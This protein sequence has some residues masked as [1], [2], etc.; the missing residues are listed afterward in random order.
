MHELSVCQGLIRQ[1]GR[2][3]AEHH[4]TRVDKIFLQI[5]PLSGVE[6]A[7]LQAAFPI[8]RHNTLV[9]QAEMVIQSMPVRI[10]CK[11]CGEESEATL[12]NLT[13]PACGD[14]NTDLLSGDE[15]LIE[16][17]EMQTAQ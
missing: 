4:A 2:I 13:C 17:I 6:P 8:A 14:W 7:L 15:L 10:R 12:N 16:R 9:E 1:V 5:G 3:A 11:T